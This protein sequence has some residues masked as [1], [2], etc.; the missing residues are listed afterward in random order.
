MK[1][2]HVAFWLCL[3]GGAIACGT[4][5]TTTPTEDAAVGSDAVA[6]GA[7]GDTTPGSDAVTTDV[8]TADTADTVS[9]AY[10]TCAAV[11]DCTQA[12]CANSTSSS[13]AASC[14][15]GGAPTAVGNATI[16]L[17]C[18]QTKC[19]DGQCKGSTD[20]NCMSNCSSMR[21]MPA[22]LSCVDT[23]T[24]G[25]GACADVKPCFE[26]CQQGK[27]NITTCI[28]GCYNKLSATAKTE[29]Q[30]FATCVANAPGTGD[31]T[32]SC[33]QQTIACFLNGQTGQKG[34]YDSIGCL[35]ACQTASDGFACALTCFGDMSA[36]GQSAYA[37]VSPCLGQDITA[38]AG[39]EDKVV[40]CL[41]P[42]GTQTCAEALGCVMGCTSGGG[43]DPTCT[44][45]CLHNTTS[46][47]DK[48]LLSKLGCQPATDPTCTTGIVDCLAPTGSAKC[49]AILN[50]AMG[51]SAGQGQP[52]DMKCL[53]ACIQTG[54]TAT[55]SAAYSAIGCL[56]NP[57]TAGCPDAM[58]AC[59]NP[60][61][62]GTCAQTQGCVQTCYLAGGD[63]NACANTCYAQASV[64][65]FKDMETWS[66]CQQG[67]NATCK[68]DA[69]CLSTCTTQQ[70]HAAKK[71]CQPT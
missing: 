46:D 52:P 54:S 12:A 64:Q 18:V 15:S 40:V 13:C 19:T 36:A 60:I 49:P 48:L 21:C 37:E 9:Y 20:P 16:L 1:I 30:A 56:G 50:C 59:Y 71:A 44:F 61:G 70:C 7:D 11:V 14:I 29:A 67:C 43:N 51:C 22:I 6:D 55:A 26:T 4:S 63:V 34:C 65:G 23:G 10:P 35:S 42:T 3:G 28:S 47:A 24:T 41:A 27:T 69:T 2:L 62:T 39:C 68:G 53:M 32:A 45:T 38:T 31:P 25:S 66:A 58:V 33:I 57:G 8:A 5:A 17:N